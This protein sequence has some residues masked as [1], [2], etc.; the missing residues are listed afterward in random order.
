MVT[1]VQ[2]ELAQ[3]ILQHERELGAKP[4]SG[5]RI[6][7]AERVLRRLA[8]GVATLVTS[9]GYR[10]LLARALR[11]AQAE[12]PILGALRIPT[13][14]EY[15]KGGPA[16]RS[17]ATDDSLVALIANL[18]ALLTTFIGDD[19]TDNIIRG[20]WPDSPSR[21]QLASSGGTR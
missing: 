18:I 12:F 21:R 8:P 11:L 10:T 1:T 16:P 6:G 4:E 3:W 19:L 14:G 13:S 7:L 2:R 15:L 20:V 5:A 9:T 17:G